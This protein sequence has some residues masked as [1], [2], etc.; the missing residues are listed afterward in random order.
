LKP[1][2]IVACCALVFPLVGTVSSSV[3][4]RR[5][6]LLPLTKERVAR[7]R[8]LDALNQEGLALYRQRRFTDAQSRFGALRQTA[9]ALEEFDLAARAA[10]NVGACQ[11]AIRQ[12][13]SALR[14]FLEARRL[15][16]SASD[17]SETAI[18]D[19]NLGSLYREMGDLDAAVHWTEQSFENMSGEDRKLHLREIQVTLG[20][21]RASQKRLPEALELFRQAIDGADRADDLALYARAWNRLGEELLR[22]HLLPQA[23]SALLEA[24]RVCK[25]HHL[26]LD[27]SYRNLGRLRMDQGDLT[28]ASALLDRAVELASGPAG[29]LPA[30]DMYHYRG[31]VR[32]KQG[33]LREA[34][35]DLRIAL[36]LARAWR[37]SALPDEASRIGNEGWLDQV[38]SAFIE[39][40]N[41]LYLETG[42]AALMRETF[43]AAEEN[44]ASSL[45]A[46]FKERQ[47]QIADLPPSYW[48][49]IAGLQRAEIA[50]LRSAGAASQQAVQATRA[51]LGIMEAAL[52]SPW[53]PAPGE[54]LSRAASALDPDSLLLSF[55]LGESISW[56]WAVDRTGP[57]LYSLPP[58]REIQALAQ[59]AAD[60]IREDTQ[61]ASSAGS[62]L[63]QTLFGPLA[64]R[65]QQKP[66]WLLS[67][68]PALLDVPVAA[69]PVPSLSKLEHS[70]SKESRPAPVYVVERHTTEVIPGAGYWLEATGRPERTDPAPLF[71]GVGDPIYNTADPR[72]GGRLPVSHAGLSWPLRLTA[73]TRSDSGR[74]T[75]AGG[76]ILP[77]LVASSSEL[78]ACSR[79]WNG[80]SVLLKG[81]DASRRN[82]VDQLR[83]NPAV[84]HF[85]THILG[86]K[87]LE[88]HSGEGLVPGLAEGLVPGSAGLGPGSAGRPA[89]G[90]IA[91]SLTDRNEP[92]LLQPAE[93][94]GWKLDAGLVV[95]SGCASA[96]GTVL[97]GTGL[98][99]LTRAWLAA[100]A[101]SVV[102]SRWA[103]PDED[104]GL[105]RA[106]YGYLSGR[107]PDPAQ[108]LRAAQLEMIHSP[109]WRARP[110]Y[111]G[112]YFMVGNR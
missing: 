81:A 5:T 97:Q 80:Q 91:L 68:D 33:R 55:Q 10:T 23:E 21:L 40:G 101:Q 89:Y 14:T 108:A 82:L 111:W 41:R 102:G 47:A 77:R 57:V 8:S 22:S 16:E 107:R 1:A 104:G 56:L 54:V 51:Q 43:E 35:D 37:W 95:L 34:V 45:R 103:T 110:R 66:R 48:E 53:Q 71:V 24:Y 112:A 72:R 50:A 65:F 76:L 58:R 13:Q 31:R 38:Y 52:V 70:L 62:A 7:R 75:D 83:R 32:L 64:P 105:F 49:A 79:S 99:G 36:R 69:L 73:A 26:P 19:A 67:L 25:L 39:A 29:P 86:T 90:L 88:D 98:M 27:N 106:F 85:A 109:G 42:D 28:S 6:K 92:E 2:Q 100:G 9:A 96:E 3:P 44:R 4:H 87:V 60:A 93:I 46:L 17:T 78:D 84:V 12:Y 59:A 18:V 61:E 74:V 15:A 20:S 94:A 11:F 63:Y 30:W